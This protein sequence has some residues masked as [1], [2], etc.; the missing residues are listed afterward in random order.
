MPLRVREEGRERSLCAY[1]CVLCENFLSPDVRMCNVFM[2]VCCVYGM[3]VRTN[4]AIKMYK[5]LMCEIHGIAIMV[6]LKEY[7]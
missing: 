2:Y 1:L 5:T 6:F 7:K 4:E 3:I